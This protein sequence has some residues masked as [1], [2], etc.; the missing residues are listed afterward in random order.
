MGYV[1]AVAGKGG[2]GKTTISAFIID[3][4][5]K[6]LKGTILASDADPNSNLADALG[7]K[8]GETIVGILEGIANSTDTVPAGMTKER[9]IDLK[10]Q[11]S[12]VE[13]PRF[14]LLVMGRPEGPG[15]YCYAN[16]VLR[17]II[18]KLEKNYDYIVMDN[19]AG[20][21]H[22]SRR[23]RRKIDLLLLV[24]DATVVGIRS[25]K[26]IMDL[27]N[28]LEIEITKS[29]LLVNRSILDVAP[30]KNEAKKLGLDLLEILPEDPRI[31]ELKIENKSVLGL[32]QDAELRTLLAEA[33]K[34]R[35]P[36]AKKIVH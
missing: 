15:C 23:T 10:V 22:L 12:L 33:L 2:T 9:Y 20:M 13:T 16:N 4:L 8:E 17:G 32:T 30:I 18:E 27:A 19:E 5:A 31:N 7:L 25:A 21:E 34:K 3:W 28:E 35:C 36:V 26:R 11:E 14:D 24:S 6:E 1:I 29:T